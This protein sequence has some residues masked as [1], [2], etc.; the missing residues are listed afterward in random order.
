MAKMKAKKMRKKRR[1]QVFYYFN[2]NGSCIVE[3]NSEEE[4]RN[5][6]TDGEYTAN[7]EDTHDYEISEIEEI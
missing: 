5:M 4:A 2:G 7:S 6:F 1:W 3:A